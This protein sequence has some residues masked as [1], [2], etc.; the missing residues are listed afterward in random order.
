MASSTDVDG[1]ALRVALGTALPDNALAHAV[2]PLEH[3]LRVVKDGQSVGSA[4][5]RHGV[6]AALTRS[7][8]LSSVVVPSS[9]G[10]QAVV[11]W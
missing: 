11:S 9:E 8:Q 6:L 3:C 2:S 10:S 5:R 4:T 7:M 1:D